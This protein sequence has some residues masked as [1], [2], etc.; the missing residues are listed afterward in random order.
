MQMSEKK[1][2]GTTDS[3]DHGM[4][5]SP[6]TMEDG[7]MAVVTAARVVGNKLKKVC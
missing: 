3:T 1:R 5:E 2:Y 4:E 6:S 7:L